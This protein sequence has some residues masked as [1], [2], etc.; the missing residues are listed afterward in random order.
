M[1][2][3]FGDI[4]IVSFIAS[5]VF[6]FHPIH[7]ESVS[8]LVGRADA[9]SGL[10]FLLSLLFYTKSINR[11]SVFFLGRFLFLIVFFFVVMNLL[12]LQYGLVCVY[13]FNL[14]LVS[15]LS[16]YFWNTGLAMIACILSSLSKE[17]GITGNTS[18]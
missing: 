5:I 2:A 8:S 1:F 10:F 15:L 7:V 9:L 13:L 11:N 4:F 12:Y 6:L 18:F 17:V 16:L 14:L 3:M